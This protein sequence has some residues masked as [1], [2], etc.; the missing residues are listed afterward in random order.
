MVISK[1]NKRI[2]NILL[3]I[4]LCFS[5]IFVIIFIHPVFAL[6]SN[7]VDPEIPL[8][9]SSNGEDV[10][11]NGLIINSPRI[12]NNYYQ[13]AVSVSTNDVYG[14]CY[15]SGNNIYVYLLS[16]F[17][18]TY[19]RADNQNVNSIYYETQS[20]NSI[21]ISTNFYTCA[22][23]IPS[24]SSGSNR[25]TLNL[26]LFS[27]LET[28]LSA[29]RDYIDNVG[30]S[31][32]FY[33]F[34]QVHSS[35]NITYE[36]IEGNGVMVYASPNTY[37]LL[38]SYAKPD[39]PTSQ[40]CYIDNGDGTSNLAVFSSSPLTVYSA[41]MNGE[42][43]SYDVCSWYDVGKYFYVFPEVIQNEFEDSF[44]S[45]EEA[46]SFFSGAEDG[47]SS[48]GIVAG[49]VSVDVPAGN[50]LY[51]KP[52]A[53]SQARLEVQYPYLSNSKS[54]YWSSS[55]KWVS[56]VSSL[57]ATGTEY[58]ISGMTS[59][60]WSLD[61][62]KGVD[63]YGRG[64]YGYTT[65]GSFNAGWF[66]VWNPTYYSLSS[67]LSGDITQPISPTITVSMQYASEYYIYPL[68][69]NLF[70][71]VTGSNSDFN[72][73]WQGTYSE[74]EET[75][76]S[77]WDKIKHDV[78]SEDPETGGEQAGAIGGN[79]SIS[80]YLQQLKDTLSNFANNFV[81]LLKAPIAHIQQ[82]I[83][84]GSSF[85]NVFGQM[86]TWLPPEVYAVLTSALVLFIVIGVLKLLHR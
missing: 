4:S 32:S 55:V 16:D 23:Y 6:G 11:S 37:H 52:R 49:P 12:S 68:T 1:S 35:T 39:A 53:G 86:F 3:I 18:F 8:Y 72:S 65:Y 70:T 31:G 61:T 13:V 66:V 27:D 60:N 76:D 77:Q 10:F 46:K 19:F 7:E 51:V 85:F 47:A 73:Y 56:G 22:F 71:G 78:T 74:D 57:P 40:Y 36:Y 29:I 41:F 33:S 38:G 34:P 75:G 69:E 45:L 20:I 64:Y 80:D 30:S 14:F 50:V 44:T 48:G 15:L 82:L 24:N 43:Y 2:A 9:I 58:P 26:P 81:D 63:G 62:S 17:P 79:L 25:T 83:S 5:I 84:A 21:N 42:T 67:S 59:I 54:P 28:G